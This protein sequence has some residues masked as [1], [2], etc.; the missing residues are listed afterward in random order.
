MNNIDVETYYTKKEEI[1]ALHD[2]TASRNA[3]AEAFENHLI[4]EINLTN[5]QIEE[6]K[7]NMARTD[8]ENKQKKYDEDKVP[9]Q[10]GYVSKSK[11]P[12]TNKKKSSKYS[13]EEK[14][15]WK[16]NLVSDYFDTDMQHHASH[17]KQ[18]RADKPVARL[19]LQDNSW[20]KDH[21]D[22]DKI[23]LHGNVSD[24]SMN[25]LADMIQAKG[26]EPVTLEGT[27]EFKA[28]AWLELGQR[29]IQVDD[30]YKP[31][32]EMVKALEAVGAIKESKAEGNDP[33]PEPPLPSNDNDKDKEVEIPAPAMG[34]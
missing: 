34:M 19:Q 14:Q 6:L 15:N 11:K 3:K 9:A 21:T 1:L 22:K 5:K 30:S 13:D 26:W 31:S 10:T 33:K 28:R 12:Q 24:Q 17:I 25:M 29:D 4:N 32:K 16:A 2:A 23:A 8:N 27:D 18:F 20:L 7:K